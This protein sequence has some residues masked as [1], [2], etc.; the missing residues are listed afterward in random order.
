[1]TED[2]ARKALAALLEIVGDANGVDII[3]KEKEHE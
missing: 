3:A 2:Q 1:M